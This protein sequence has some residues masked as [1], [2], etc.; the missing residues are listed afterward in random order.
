MTAEASLRASL[1][2]DANAVQPDP[3]LGERII[4]ASLSMTGQR[5]AGVRLRRPRWRNWLLPAVAAIAVAVL[6]SSV[7][8]ARALLFT[9]EPAAAPRPTPAPSAPA[10]PA[11]APRPTPTANRPTATSSASASP[12]GGLVP[13]T[14]RSTASVPSIGPAGG[15]VPVGFRA[16]DLTW[17][18]AQDGWALGTAPCATRPCT[19]LVRT[20]DGG[21]SWVGIPA[22][23]AELSQSATCQQACVGSL[24]FADRL[25]GY[26][27]GADALFTSTDG[28]A[29]WLR[30]P[31]QADALEIGD[32]VVLRVISQGPGCRPDCQYRLRR[33]L[34]GSAEWTDVP[35]P[36]VTTR[37]DGVTLARSGHLAAI[38]ISGHAAGGAGN[39]TSSLLVS[40]DD[41][42]TWVSRDE[43]CP[44]TGS[45]TAGHEVDSSALTAAPDGSVSLLCTPRG[46]SS[47]QFTITSTDGGRSFHAAPPSLNHTIATISGASANVL[48]A[49]SDGVYRST[50][51]GRYWQ[52]VLND[53][54]TRTDGLPDVPFL[55]FENPSTGRYLSRDGL[56]VWTT[57]DAGQHWIRAF[58][59]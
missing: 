13:V 52:R 35:L 3:D 40:A 57:T 4:V 30:Q 11:P 5:H 32:G 8:L 23:L 53:Q 9:D 55:G 41:G 33:T 44:Q 25:V 1:R 51:G 10:S 12:A 29:N 16:V 2:A 56:T 37:G 34:I 36:A 46:T 26:A 38:M 31:G 39:A 50:D 43:P 42:S 28:G 22:P 47:A 15:P 20:T 45:Q 7:L 19:S 49:V 6:L 54:T 18:S 24:R 17:T 59:R 48:L 27:F 14:P 21:R 58:F